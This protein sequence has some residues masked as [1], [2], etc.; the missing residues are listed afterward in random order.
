MPFICY[1]CVTILLLAQNRVTEVTNIQRI[2]LWQTS[3]K[4]RLRYERRN[5]PMETYLSISTFT[6]MASVNMSF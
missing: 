6:E 3:A 4:N 1:L 2:G 5:L